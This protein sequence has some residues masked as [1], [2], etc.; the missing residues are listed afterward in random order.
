MNQPEPCILCNSSRFRVMHRVGSWHYLCCLE[1]SLVSL[2]PRPD[3]SVLLEKY[4]DYLPVQ[5]EK[6]TQWESMM[7]PVYA[8]AIE[9]I[10]SRIGTR[11]EVLL[12]IG[13]GHGFFLQQMK[14]LGWKVEGIEV[15]EVGRN[16]TEQR[17]GIHVYGQP[18][19]ELNLPPNSYH[20][21][22]LFYVI[23]HIANPVKLLK[24]VYRILRPDGLLLLRWPHSTP[25]VMLIK[26][27]AH[28]FDL[29]HTPY[30]LYDFSPKTMAHMLSVCGFRDVKTVIGG[31]TIPRQKL[32]RYTAK[33]MGYL[34]ETLYNIS[35]GHLLLPGAS[36]TSL[37][38]K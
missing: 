19:D 7:K 13:C 34:G 10:K 4:N 38:I 18:L 30:H 27:L 9:M 29:Y 20:V 24:E 23:E 3:N 22:T 25:A 26:P 12:D 1:C 21:V 5:P 17:C 14:S 36:K 11:P 32:K 28:I 6:I 15:S 35:H 37:A 16:Y 31:Y 2:H 33:T 8:R